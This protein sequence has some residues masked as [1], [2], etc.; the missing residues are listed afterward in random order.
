[1]DREA[2]LRNVAFGGAWSEQIV[3][4][5]L[6]EASMQRLDK[7]VTDT[8]YEDLRGFKE[9]ARALDIVCGC[10]PKGDL[11]RAAWWKG[12]TITN[13]GLRSRELKRIADALRSGIGERV[14][15]AGL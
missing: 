10:H 9:V 4:D 15:S 5:E 6:L 11:L 3:G 14:R 8:L 12:L 2:Q 1:M 7:A 13:S